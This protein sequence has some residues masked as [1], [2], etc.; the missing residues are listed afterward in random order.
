MKLTFLGHS[1][2]VL[3]SSDGRI[4]VDPFLSGNPLCPVPIDRIGKLDT[5]LVTHGHGDHLGDTVAL[6]RRDGAAVVCVPEIGYWLAGQGVSRRVEMN[7]GGT[8]RFPWGSAKMT[9]ALHSSSIAT[10]SGL[11]DGGVCCGFL[12]RMGGATV[13]HAGD[14]CLTS[15]FALLANQSVDVALLPVGGHY[16]MDEWDAAQAMSMIRP[17]CVVPMHY[18]TF[19]AIGADMKRLESLVPPSVQF[20]PLKSG[21]SLELSA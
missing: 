11:V 19:P 17:T 16:T 2:F 13:Y 1:A 20:C 3:E 9:P 15:D 8:A 7:L 12:I 18:D 10:P 6:A 5:I 14:T 21:E 4:I